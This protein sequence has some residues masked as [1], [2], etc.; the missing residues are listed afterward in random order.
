MAGHCFCFPLTTSFGLELHLQRQAIRAKEFLGLLCLSHPILW[1]CR[2]PCKAAEHRQVCYSITA[3]E[4][5][6]RVSETLSC[7]PAVTS[8]KE[9]RVRVSKWCHCGSECWEA[10]KLSVCCPYNALLTPCSCRRPMAQGAMPTAVL[11]HHAH[12]QEALEIR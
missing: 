6:I 2:V 10:T 9:N 1:L 3:V 11:T 5:I 8:C 7:S 12:T 4:I